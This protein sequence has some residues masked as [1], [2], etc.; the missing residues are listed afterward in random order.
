MHCAISDPFL[1]WGSCLV[2]CFE[3]IAKTDG[4]RGQ[5]CEATRVLTVAMSWAAL[6]GAASLICAAALPVDSIV[7]RYHK[8]PAHV[9]ST[10]VPDGPLVGNGQTGAAINFSQP[11]QLEHLDVAFHI[12][13]NAFFAAPTSN[14]SSCGY[15]DLTRGGRK[16]LGG[17]RLTLPNATS[18]WRVPEL[19]PANGTFVLSTGHGFQLNALMHA[20]E[21]VLIVNLSSSV[22]CTVQLTLWTYNGCSGVPNPQAQANTGSTLPTQAQVGEKYLQVA[23]ATGWEYQLRG[24]A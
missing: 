9:P 12:G 6:L 1:D 16:A 23:R 4:S 17:L 11:G 19:F 13:H 18:T 8:A 2:T 5:P 3:A 7:S 10:G 21:D 15:T 24:P 22:P 20:V 14:I